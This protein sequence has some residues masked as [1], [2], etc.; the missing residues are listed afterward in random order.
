VNFYSDN[1]NDG[2]ESCTLKL[3][4]IDTLETTASVQIP[5]LEWYID[6]YTK[7]VPL[8]YAMVQS[9]GKAYGFKKD[10]EIRVSQQTVSEAFD[11]T[12]FQ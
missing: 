10:L 12:V 5:Y 6:F 3:S 9:S 11:F 8:R 2:N 1:C 7:N 4:I